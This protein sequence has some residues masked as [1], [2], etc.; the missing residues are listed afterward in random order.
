MVLYSYRPLTLLSKE[1]KIRACYQ[2]CCLKYVSSGTMT[3]QTLRERFKVEEKDVSIVSRIIKD[4]VAEGMI[5]LSD[6]ES[7]SRKYSR[8][9]PIWA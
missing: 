8:Y 7:A 4:A 3:N 1:E 5:K 6:P 2:H 9:V